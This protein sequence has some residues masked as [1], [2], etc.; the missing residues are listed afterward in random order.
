[1]GHGSESEPC[2]T[3]LVIDD[4]GDVRLAAERVLHRHGF[5][6]LVAS[7]GSQGIEL[8][9]REAGIGIVLLD[10][11]MPGLGGAETARELGRIHPGISIIAMSGEAE[12]EVRERLQDVDLAGFVPKPFTI[13]EL[14]AVVHGL[15]GR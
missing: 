6:V 5:T 13:D 14:L 10:L 7:D 1:M 15:R 4:D 9:Q 12:R 11:N 8:L 2:S 3:V